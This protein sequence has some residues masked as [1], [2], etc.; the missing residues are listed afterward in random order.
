MR[1]TPSRPPLPVTLAILLALCLAVTVTAVRVD[2]NAELA[3]ARSSEQAAQPERKAQ[4]D[5]PTNRAGPT[6]THAA[7]VRRAIRSVAAPWRTRPVRRAAPQLAQSWSGY[8]FDA[9]RAPAQRVMDRWLT[10]S[11]FIGVGIYLGGIHRACE[12]R[13]LNRRW[14]ARQTEAGWQLLPIWVGPQAS[15][16]GY[17][18]RIPR[19]PGASGRY[20]AARADGAR[21]ARQAVGV[22]R[23]LGVARGSVLFY[24][25]EPF[26]SES[27]WCRGSALAFL[28]SW[29]Q[30]VR[31]LQYRSGVYS[32]VRSAIALLSRTPRGYARPDAVWYAWIARAGASPGEYVAQPA[33]IQAG[34]VHQ[35]VLDTRVRYGGISMAID[36]NHVVLG[37][38]AL[39]SAP[40]ACG[41][42]ADQ[43]LPLP[44]RVGSR[45]VTVRAVECLLRTVV[46]SHARVDGV[47]DTGTLRAVRN[48][49]AGRG[50][51]PT[52]VVD[53]P[54]W[55]SLLSA[56]RTPL[57]KPGSAGEPVRRL[58]RSLNAALPHRVTVDGAFGPETARAVRHYQQRTG[59]A[60]TSVVTRGTWSALGRGR[61][62]GP[63][64]VA[65]R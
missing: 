38:S 9:C 3:A 6:A 55:T 57:L 42:A 58:Q 36:W 5:K 11:P 2:R 48:F 7:V 4:P 16:T 28:E 40:A 35:Y 50:L 8:A 29:T 51:R 31:R 65:R 25:L 49:Q 22:A 45:G 21:Q 17:D 46:R 20:P 27:R 13:H 34:R 37:R 33:A 12:Q 19:Q 54:T 52:G 60:A 64:V 15:C 30:E 44:L 32:H 63:V 24:D 62:A 47:Y 10:R 1:L 26:P 53:R 14:V 43:V 61:V 39:R 23:R 59:Q 56:G 41:A 18:H